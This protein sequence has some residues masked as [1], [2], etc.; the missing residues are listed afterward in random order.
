MD[1][2]LRSVSGLSLSPD[3]ER[4][5]M[6]RLVKK[7]DELL[8][9]AQFLLTTKK[10]I[11]RHNRSLMA[12]LLLFY[13]RRCSGNDVS[14][15]EAELEVLS[16]STKEPIDISTRKKISDC[17]IRVYCEFSSALDDFRPEN[18]NERFDS[19]TDCEKIVPK[20]WREFC[21]LGIVLCH[22]LPH[23]RKFE[24]TG[25]KPADEF[26]AEV[27]SRWGFQNP[28]TYF[29][30]TGNASMPQGKV[31]STIHVMAGSSLDAV[32]DLVTGYDLSNGTVGGLMFANGTM[33]VVTAGHCAIRKQ[34][35]L[36]GETNDITAV[37]EPVSGGI[38][39]ADTIDVDELVIT[40][41][42]F[43]CAVLPF[44]QQDSAIHC[45]NPW[46]MDDDVSA[47][48]EYFT[49]LV[50]SNRLSF[51]S[52]TDSISPSDNFPFLSA[53]LLYPG[54]AIVKIGNTTGN[55][56]GQL[57]GIRNVTYT[58]SSKEHHVV[59]AVV[60]Q[61]EPG[62]RFASGGDSGSVYYA[63]MG[64]FSFPIAIH[65]AQVIIE[66]PNYLEGGPPTCQVVSIG[67]PLREVVE[68][69]RE[70]KDGS[71]VVWFKKKDLLEKEGSVIERMEV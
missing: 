57:I 33:Y 3:K 39:L 49:A 21:E 25:M 66:T 68:K 63:K 7:K 65:R 53:G 71:D 6:L 23:S 4:R 2:I 11:S 28:R 36:S 46:Y 22:V 31:E 19:M 51:D 55:T 17:I 62:Q 64:S 58:E 67:T 38:R 42:K 44:A 12:H 47:N 14:G 70:H 8:E 15:I 9:L 69:F 48:V 32:V 18:D 56:S 60:V 10:Y 35:A 50:R 45:A 16:S 27:T 20:Y 37:G 29:I 24:L 61:W 59:G 40:D 52:T 34:P 30:Y 1:E 5:D 26:F 13:R 41:D 54:T 43:D